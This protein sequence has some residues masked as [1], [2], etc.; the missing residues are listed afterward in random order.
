MAFTVQYPN[1]LVPIS[2]DRWQKENNIHKAQIANPD[3][4]WRWYDDKGRLAFVTY[5]VNTSDGSKKIFP[6]TYTLEEDKSIK[7][8]RKRQK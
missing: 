8:N 4:I 2:D 3:F 6:L 1:N 7:I 5:R